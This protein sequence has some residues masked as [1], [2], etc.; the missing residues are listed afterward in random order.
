MN[1]IVRK[2]FWSCIFLLILL[3]SAGSVSP[4]KPISGLSPFAEDT[5]INPHDFTNFYYWTN[6]IVGK[7]I[8]G[9]PTGS[10]GLSIFSNS[11]NPVH[12]NIRVIATLPAYDENAGMLFWYSLGKIGND[13]FTPDKNGWQA[14][15]TADLF[16]IYVFPDRRLQDPRIFVT[17]RQAALMDNSWL[18]IMAQEDVNTLGI[19][20]IVFVNYTPK[21]FTEEGHEMMNYMGKKN[22]MAADDTPI[23]KSLEDLNLMMKHELIDTGMIKPY[24]MYAIAPVISD[25]TNGVIA[26]DA[27]YWFATKDGSPLPAER[28]FSD[29]FGCLQKTWNWCKE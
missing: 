14:K 24:P 26:P 9:R 27:F 25:P 16:P 1:R 2:S 29:Q 22:G 10:D 23:I 15:Q 20:R 6:G 11:S 3:I 5:R 17:A 8:I 21:A 28:M 7:S 4:Q 18:M 13:A 12:R 19:R